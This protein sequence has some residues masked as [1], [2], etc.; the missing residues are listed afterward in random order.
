MSLKSLFA[1]WKHWRAVRKS[2]KQAD[3]GF[4]YALSALRDPEYDFRE[5]LER[6]AAA[7]PDCAFSMGMRIALDGYRAPHDQV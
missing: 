4:E 1:D 3:Q 2:H 7:D 6:Q 5:Q